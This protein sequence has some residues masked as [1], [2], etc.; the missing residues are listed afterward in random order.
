MG[1]LNI[2]YVNARGDAFVLNGDGWTF[3]ADAKPLRRFEWNYN[4]T[5]RI[6]GMGGTANGFARRPRTITLEVGQRGS[7][8]EDMADRAN[9]LHD[10]ADADCA[11]ET[12]GRL[13]VGDQYIR[14]FLAVAGGVKAAPI[15][16]N[17]IIRE[18]TILAVEPYWSTESTYVF[19]IS[20]GQ[21]EID[22]TGKKYNLRY[23]YRYGMG[24]QNSRFVNECYSDCPCIY[25]FYGPVRDPKVIISGHTYEVDVVL[26]QHERVVIDQVA[27]TIQKI[28]AT[29]AATNVFN[30][31]NKAYDIF[32]KLP[33]GESTISY[34]GSFRWTLTLVEQRSEL[35]WTA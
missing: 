28:G 26:Q 11:A 22:L 12:P 14:C 15:N 17:F 7:S 4:T 18:L 1:R 30:D 19:N 8:R 24:Y 29:G 9:R 23:A 13:Y 2:R 20:E 33:T 32:K 27:R 35:R 3:V 21:Q 31:R 34:D 5:N 25:T 16:G 10:I 6:S